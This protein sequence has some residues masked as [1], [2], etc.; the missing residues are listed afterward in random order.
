[1]DPLINNYRARA[2]LMEKRCDILLPMINECEELLN[3]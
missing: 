3:S 1:M 2:E